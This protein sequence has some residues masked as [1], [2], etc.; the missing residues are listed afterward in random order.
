[1]ARKTNRHAQHF[2]QCAKKAG[3]PDTL[4]MHLPEDVFVFEENVLAIFSTG[5]LDPTGPYLL[6]PKV[7]TK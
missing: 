6:H 5:D 7:T 3:Y 2:F 4:V 1:M